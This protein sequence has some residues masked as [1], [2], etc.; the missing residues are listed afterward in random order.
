MLFPVVPY[1][2][3]ED[4]LDF[5]Q[6]WL[7][8]HISIDVGAQKLKFYRVMLSQELSRKTKNMTLAK[9]FIC[10]FFGESQNAKFFQKRMKMSESQKMMNLVFRRVIS[11]FAS[12]FRLRVECDM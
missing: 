4:S 11:H 3:T 12:L 7:T 6:S 5:F 1:S 9:K 2:F 8:A 10:T